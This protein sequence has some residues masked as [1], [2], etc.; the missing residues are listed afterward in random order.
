M[1][2]NPAVN[3]QGADSEAAAGMKTDPVKAADRFDI[4]QD[5]WTHEP[6]LHHGDE[7]YTPGDQLCLSLVLL[8]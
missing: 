2:S 8:E 5:T 7:G 4:D 6:V 1:R 3:H